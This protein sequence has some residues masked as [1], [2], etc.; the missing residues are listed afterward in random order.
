MTTRVAPPVPVELKL[1]R[2]NAQVGATLDDG[3][4]SSASV[5]DEVAFVGRIEDGV[6]HNDAKQT[7]AAGRTA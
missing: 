1:P 2:E 5:T 4:L 3:D 6:K 7:D